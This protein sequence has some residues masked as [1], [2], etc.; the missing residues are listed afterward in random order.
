MGLDKL[1]D[2]QIKFL[3][4]LIGLLLIALTLTGGWSMNEIYQLQ[5]N[6]PKDYVQTERYDK[7]QQRVENSLDRIDRKLDRLIER[8]K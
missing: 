8:S 2:R 4:W 7:D 1:S 6:L 5:C 3:Q